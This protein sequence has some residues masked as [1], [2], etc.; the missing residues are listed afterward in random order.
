MTHLAFFIAVVA[1]SL[2]WSA[3]MT[4]AAA[5]VQR[6]WLRQLLVALAVVAPALAVLPWLAVSFMLAFAAKL[7]VNWFGPV[8]T[9]FLAG[10]IGGGWIV[11]AGLRPTV[12]GPATTP[13]ARWPLVGLVAAFLLAKVVVAG[14]LLTLDSG[15]TGRAAGMKA[16]AVEL[17]QANLPPVVTDAANAAPLYQAAFEA[18]EA[19]PALS[20]TDSPLSM[21]STVDVRNAA[22]VDLVARHSQTLALVREAASRDDCRFARDWTRPSLDMVLPEMQSLRQVARLVQLVARRKSATGNAAG[23]LDDV[24]LLHRIGQ[25][26]AAEPILISG[27]VGRAIDAIALDT[28]A[29]VL[30][31]LGPSD[32]DRLDNAT[33]RDLV[34][35]VP[36]FKRHFFGEEAFGT[37]TFATFC[38][39]ASPVDSFDLLATMGSSSPVPTVWRAPL[40][41]LIGMLYRVFLLPEDFQA[42]RSTLRAYQQLLA[43]QKS[44]SDLSREAQSIEDALHTDHRGMVTSLLAPALSSCLR[45]GV[46]S[47]ALH[48][49]AAVAVAATRYRLENGSLPESL[50]NLRP[51]F[52]PL[53]PADPF[54]AN[55]PLR[56][57]QND[58][59]IVIYSVG[60]DGED[61]GG[62]S[63]PDTDPGAG[64]D[65]V[66]LRLRQSAARTQ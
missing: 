61:D 21:S 10:T 15:I 14:T 26:A 5:R 12:D 3:A 43:R 38:D 22:I 4:A 52:L 54:A 46:R 58:D 29:Q 63:P 16:E 24:A 39:N 35:V 60:P 56:L 32:L 25:H 50:D 40:T 23:A 64:N 49:A 7:Q 13:A 11:R 19:D 53:P 45:S 28:L 33:I 18:F 48:R 27:L 55:T 37:M 31:E 41:P 66:G 8:L 9:T 42:Y 1:A 30:P 6:L 2:L 65:D 62:P 20:G 47:Q 34:Y 51:D 59:G 57:K 36:S 17:I 44:F